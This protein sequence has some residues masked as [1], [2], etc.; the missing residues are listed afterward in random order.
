MALINRPNPYQTEMALLESAGIV[1]KREKPED[2]FLSAMDGAG[3][4]PEA[5][6][7]Q[8]SAIMACGE[9]DGVKLAAAREAL[10][11]YM[12]PA[13]VDLRKKEDAA[14]NTSITFNIQ[15][16]NVQL[17]NV[18]RPKGIENGISE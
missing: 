13:Y 4:T 11:L 17:N 2:T 9:N 10:K 1:V 5:I 6:L 15:G 14:Q 3:L 7:G 16:E 18:L 8:I 12:H